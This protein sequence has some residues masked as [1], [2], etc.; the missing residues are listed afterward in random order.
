MRTLVK[1][2]LDREYGLRRQPFVNHIPVK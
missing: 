1:T 2:A